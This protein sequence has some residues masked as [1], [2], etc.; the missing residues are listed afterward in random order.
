MPSTSTSAWPGH[1]VQQRTR[2]VTEFQ[3]V[4]PATGGH[5]C[6][7]AQEPRKARSSKTGS[8]PA[9]PSRSSRSSA[10]GIPIPLPDGG[11]YLFMDKDDVRAGGDA[12]RGGDR[13]GMAA[14]FLKDGESVDIF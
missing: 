14:Q 8:A 3:H 12:G 2:T 11:R 5:Q 7:Q 9:K 1:Q 6:D 4:N 10:K 13:W